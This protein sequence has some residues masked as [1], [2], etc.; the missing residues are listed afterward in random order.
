[1]ASLTLTRTQRRR[2]SLGIQY[3]IFA[4]IVLLFALSADWKQLGASFFRLDIAASLFPDIITVALRNTAVFTLL[5]FIFG[6]A[7]GLLI[8]LMRLSRVP[9]YR[10]LGT[11][12][13]EIF[14]GLPALLWLFMVAYAVP[15]A[16]PEYQIAG[17]V[18]G[19]VTIGL[20]M[21]AAAYMSETIRA[22]IPAVPKG[23]VEAARSLGMSGTRAMLSI[24]LPQAF[25]IV[26]P[27]LTNEIILLVKDSSLAYVLGVTATSIELTKFGSD[28][29]NARVNP[30]P[31]VI[32]GL[33]YL[34]ICLPLSQ[35]V[36]RLER[37]YQKSR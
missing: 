24:V 3:G 22:G 37:R 2:T 9:P 15:T 32:A 35:L 18:Y 12:Y 6:L 13:V 10:W 23:Q 20:G 27:P 30:T 16:F 14:R 29:V 1:M 28:Q 17:G 8:A 36:Q 21:P 31:L 34:I 25:R 26:I 19:Q 11:I 4:V 5:S 7:V 33:C